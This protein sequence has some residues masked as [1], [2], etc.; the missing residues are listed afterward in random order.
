MKAATPVRAGNRP[1]RTEFDAVTLERGITQTATSKV[2]EP[3]LV[4]Q[5][6]APGE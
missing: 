3:G 2:G 6:P 1:G 4:L 5:A